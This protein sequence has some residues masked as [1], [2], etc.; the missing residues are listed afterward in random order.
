[1]SVNTMLPTSIYEIGAITGAVC[2][3]FFARHGKWNCMMVCNGLLAIAYCMLMVA[4]LWAIYIGRF[5]AGMAIGGIC[6][7]G[8]KM[9][10]EIC[11]T[12]FT[13]PFGTMGQATIA[14]GISMP[15]WTGFAFNYADVALIPNWTYVRVMWGLPLVFLTTQIVL[16]LTVF[17]LDTPHELKRW[18]QE[19]NLKKVMKKLYAESEVA[20][21][22]AEIEVPDGDLL[23]SGS[24]LGTGSAV[25]VPKNQGNEPTYRMVLFDP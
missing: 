1:M 22:I 10:N 8:S 3:G 24:F 21:R 7:F 15:T 18:G 16:M 20:V 12:E 14:I 17:S 19:E 13:G 9:L 11:P 6:V 5:F 25:V 4:N 23:E 2:G